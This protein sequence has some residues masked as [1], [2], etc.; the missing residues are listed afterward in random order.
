MLTAQQL[1]AQKIIIRKNYS[2]LQG[3]VTSKPFLI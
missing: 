1:K 3:T 2:L